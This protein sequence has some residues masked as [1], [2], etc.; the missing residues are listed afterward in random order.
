ML[1]RNPTQRWRVP[2]QGGSSR[3][4][5]LRPGQCWALRRKHFKLTAQLV[6]MC[7][8]ELL[9]WRLRVRWRQAGRLGDPQGVP[10]TARARAAPSF[11]TGHSIRSSPL[12]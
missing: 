11:S 2:R 6:R 8:D 4:N 5:V 3:T 1:T 7:A 10:S 9:E 12:G